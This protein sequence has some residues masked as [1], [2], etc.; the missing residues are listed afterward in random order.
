MNDLFQD[1][2]KFMTGSWKPVR[3]RDIVGKIEEF[4]EDTDDYSIDIGTDSQ[5]GQSTKFATVIAV[6]KIGKGGIFFYHSLK[7]D[8]IHTFYDRIYR[9]TAMSIECASKLL[10][11][12]LDRELLRDITIHC[13][14][15]PNGKTKH[16]IREITGYVNSSGF[17]CKIK[18]E[19]TVAYT[20]ADKFCKSA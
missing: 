2:T 3:M 1:S 4:L 7:V 15:G 16:M 19:G 13:D 9:E 17:E 11:L 14:V 8:K 5:N 20:I 10:E 12:F 6:H 18:P